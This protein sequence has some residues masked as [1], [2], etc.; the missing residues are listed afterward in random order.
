MLFLENMFPNES[1]YPLQDARNEIKAGFFEKV[2]FRTSREFKNFERIF[3]AREK[4]NATRD[5]LDNAAKAYLMHKIPGYDGEGIPTVQQLNALTG[6]SKDRAMFC[7]KTL[8]A[9]EESRE[10]E[11]KLN[12]IMGAVDSNLNER[13]LGNDL[14]QLQESNSHPIPDVDAYLAEQANQVQANQQ[15]QANQVQ[16]EEPSFEIQEYIAQDLAA[17][18]EQGMDNYE[19]EDDS[20]ENDNEV[21][22]DDEELGLD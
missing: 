1:D 13:G 21:E 19:Y 8:M 10:Y 20:I 2:F 12:S 18:D 11:E 9:N 14:R 5:Q 15:Q 7:I 22:K 3:N 6:K 16:E 17:E 4:G